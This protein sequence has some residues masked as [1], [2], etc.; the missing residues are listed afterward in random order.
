MAT[1]P[2]HPGLPRRT[3]LFAFLVYVFAL[4]PMLGAAHQ[5]E[6]NAEHAAC[7]LCLVHSQAYAA[8]VPPEAPA[9]A[10]ILLLVLPEDAPRALQALP[11]AHAAR[12]PPS[13]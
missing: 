4:L 13:A 12:G 5:H 3:W 7:Q 2:R 6:E 10:A 1:A 11:A 8:P 9:A